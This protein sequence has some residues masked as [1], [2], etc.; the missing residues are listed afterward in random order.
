MHTII[1]WAH[2]AKRKTT[3]GVQ[4]AFELLALIILS[5]TLVVI[6][7]VLVNG[8]TYLETSNMVWDFVIPQF[9]LFAM[10]LWLLFKFE[11]RSTKPFAL[12]RFTK[13]YGTGILIGIG[14]MSAITIPILLFFHQG[15]FLTTLN[16]STQNVTMVI[17]WLLFF[18]I[19]G[20]SE[21]LMVRSI[22]MPTIAR[23]WGVKKSVIITA[24][25]FA[26]LHLFNPNINLLGFIN[27]FISG[28]IF[29]V[30]V[31]YYESFWEVFAF[32]SFWNFVMG[33]VYGISVSGMDQLNSLFTANIQGPAILTGGAFGV[34]A[35]I[36]ATI[37][38]LALLF[39]FIK[40]YKKRF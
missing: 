14:S 31:Y 23:Q 27:L 26:G 15:E 24:L 38:E 2:D 35:S 10:C 7:G 39:Y 6:A 25:L 3:V 9:A 18:L 12:K 32:H 19:Q 11:K 33:N 30:M 5:D 13:G 36:I 16:L 17:F 37:V 20:A 28:L 1:Q 40:K 22:I 8:E 34:E 29:G 4:L 21:E